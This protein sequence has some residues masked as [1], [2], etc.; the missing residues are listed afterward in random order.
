[1]T[2]TQEMVLIGLIVKDLTENGSWCGETH[3][4]KT[5]YIA[6]HVLN[7]PIESEFVLYKHGPYSFDLNKSLAHMKGR[8]ILSLKANPGYGPSYSLNSAYW[9]S[10]F[11]VVKVSMNDISDSVNRACVALAKKNVG[12]LERIATAFFVLQNYSNLSI[13][14][15]SKKINELKPH[16][17]IELSRL[18][19][20]EAKKIFS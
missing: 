10:L 18:S 1:M 2:T 4:Q 11:K 20:Q 14:Q 3:I 17:S 13:D 12:D 6:K 19:L 5:A 16:L 9:E 7:V 15:M 8:G